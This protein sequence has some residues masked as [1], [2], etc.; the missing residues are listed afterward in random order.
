[1]QSSIIFRRPG[2]FDRDC[3]A[4]NDYKFYLSF[5]N[6]NCDEYI[7]EKAWWNAYSKNA[8]PII[9]GA[10]ATSLAKLLPPGS[11]INVEGFASPKDLATYIQYMSTSRDEFKSFFTWKKE[12]KILQ[13][14]GYFKSDS[15]HYC[16]ICEA[17][18][19]NSREK[20]VYEDLHKFW[21]R[22]QC[23]PSWDSIDPDEDEY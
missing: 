13:E 5:E 8:I 10:P 15:Y 23:H 11:Y 4:I 1:M 17:L 14:H 21:S 18:N 7:T 3:E 2:H 16:R 20:K 19:Y 22:D 12:F 6:S 9:M